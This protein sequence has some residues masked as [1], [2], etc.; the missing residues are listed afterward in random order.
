[1]LL[2]FSDFLNE[3][4]GFSRII[5][6]YATSYMAVQNF[7]SN[8]KNIDSQEMVTVLNDIEAQHNRQNQVLLQRVRAQLNKLKQIMIIVDSQEKQIREKRFLM[9]KNERS[10]STVSQSD[11]HYT[12]EEIDRQVTEAISA[13]Q[14]ITKSKLPKSIVAI[15]GFF[16]PKFR[17]KAYKIIVAN[18]EKLSQMIDAAEQDLNAIYA[19]LKDE[20]EISTSEQLANLTQR[21]NIT[22]QQREALKAEYMKRLKVLLLDGLEE[23]LSSG[24]VYKNAQSRLSAYLSCYTAGDTEIRD[25]GLTIGIIQQKCNVSDDGTLDSFL[26]TIFGN[27]LYANRELLLPF[28]IDKAFVKPI[29][30]NYYSDYNENVFPLF[31]NYA[32]Q[33]LSAFNEIG[34]SLYLV[35]VTNMGGKYSEFTSFESADDNNRINIIRTEDALSKALEELSEYIIETN[36]AYLKNTFANVSEY[37]KCSIIKREI[38]I[39]I[40]S[41]I[42]EVLSPEMLGKVEGIVRNGN[43]C[44]VIPFI[45]ISSDELQVSGIISQTRVNAVNSILNL[46]DCIRMSSNGELSLGSGTFQFHIPPQVDQNKEQ[47]IIQKTVLS[48]RQSAIVPL[49]EHLIPSEEYFSQICYENIII[50]I[51]IDAQGNEYSLDFNKDAAYMLVGGDPSSGKSSLMHTIILQAITRY[52]PDNLILYLADLKDGV[53]FDSYIKKGIRSVKAVLND[54]TENDM[55]TSFLEYIKSLVEERNALFKRVGDATGKIVRNIEQFYEVNNTECVV[56]SLPRI[57]LIIDEF[58]SLYDGGK[59]TGEITN[60]LVRMCRT[61]GIYIILASQRAQAAENANNS[62]T[63]QT[64]DYFIY[65]MMFKCPF[66]SAR[67]IVPE[68]CSDTGHPNTAVRKAQTLKKGQAIVNSNMEATEADNYIIQCYYPDNACIDETCDHIVSSQGSDSIV[69]LNSEEETQFDE[70]VFYNNAGLVLGLSNRLHYDLYNKD[71]D[72]FFDDTLVGLHI[73]P[74]LKIMACGTDDKVRSSAFWTLLSKLLYLYRSRLRINMLILDDDRRKLKGISTLL[75]H[76][77]HMWSEPTEFISYANSLS[78]DCII[79]NVL[80]NPYS[81]TTLHK[82]DWSNTPNELVSNLMSVLHRTDTVTLVLADDAKK[83]KEKCAYLDAELKCRIISVGNTVAIKSALSND[84]WEKIKESG[85]NTIRSNVI[86]AYYYN[87]GTDKLGRFRMFDIDTLINSIDF[88]SLV[89]D[90][91]D[92]NQDEFAGLTG[93]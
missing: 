6:E 12:D 78:A 22:D 44:G 18:K 51:G 15:C 4:S 53:E 80:Y 82:D 92:D 66:S 11:Q 41:N 91:P 40:L 50:P 29:C 3:Y 57:L 30:V 42:S 20:I 43:R 7:F 79:L 63:G 84:M 77:V 38:K 36:S 8:K 2:Q 56:P 32:L 26:S 76:N 64:K 55:M 24:E 54:S 5:S 31:R 33:L 65:R 27:T 69:V 48:E 74:N 75:R 39:F 37:N 59:E 86:K 47:L 58:Q 83:M 60:W 61:V 19:Q 34:V 21:K 62:F 88:S 14:K 45:G 67:Q 49:A 73:E 68:M 93:N 52:S 71:D 17:K 85:F 90:S 16:N 28:T 9:F 23:S 70:G 1:M 10:S 13:I 89:I 81:F 46:C 87:K 35:D 25:L 72:A